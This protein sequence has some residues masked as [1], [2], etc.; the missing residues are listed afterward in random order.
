M[1]KIIHVP[2]LFL[3]VVPHFRRL[4]LRSFR[5]TAIF[6]RNQSR[7]VCPA[8]G[9]VASNNTILIIQTTMEIRGRIIQVLPMASGTSKSGNAWKKQEYVLETLDQYPRKVCFN[10]FGDRVDQYPVQVGEEV[11]VSFDL[12]SREFNGRWYTDVRA[13]KID[14]ADAVPQAPVYGDPSQQAPYGA[15]TQ[16][17]FVAP[18]PVTPQFTAAPSA[19]DDLPF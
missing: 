9:G 6:A 12:E 8:S 4:L 19:T 3:Y 10:L 1:P 11:L 2:R 7:S 14:K 13:W 5:K 18:A 15:Q 17:Q 16:P